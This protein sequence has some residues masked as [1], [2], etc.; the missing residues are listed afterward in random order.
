[1]SGKD[2]GKRIPVTDGD[3]MPSVEAAMV[4]G[5]DEGVAEELATPA[6]RFAELEAQLAEAR[7]AHLRAVADLQ[8]FRRRAMEE[9]AQQLQYAN[10]GL[11]TEMLPLLDSMELATGCEVEGEGAQSLLRGVCM[12]QQQFRDL[13]A[14]YGVERIATTEQFFDSARH[15][16]VEREETND[17]CEGTILAEVQPGYVLNG[18]LLR[19]A[20]VKV[21]VQ[22]R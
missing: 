11:I 21:A 12:I 22:P 6:V 10:E 9:R 5:E 20:K 18:R 3:E 16:A 7:E 19:A 8:N 15:E 13:L 4:E 17:V 1:M 14:R 2:K